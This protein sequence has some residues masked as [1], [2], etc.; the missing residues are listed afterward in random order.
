MDKDVA[1]LLRVESTIAGAIIGIAMMM[2]V[3]AAIA[4]MAFLI[5]LSPSALHATSAGFDKP[6]RTAR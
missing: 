1:G 6:T 3:Y 4:S 5:R 2:P